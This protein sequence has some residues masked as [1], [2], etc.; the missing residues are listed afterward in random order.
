MTAKFHFIWKLVQKR[1]L[2]SPQQYF[3]SVRQMINGVNMN[4][5]PINFKCNQFS[6]HA[7]FSLQRE[8]KHLK[9]LSGV[10]LHLWNTLFLIWLPKLNQMAVKG[11]SY[12]IENYSH[13]HSILT[14][15]CHRGTIMWQLNHS[16]YLSTAG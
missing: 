10:F 13:T 5:H 12:C 16:V 8:T 7:F 4:L 15:V 1:K 6:L 2:Y 9:G 14:H 3:M 11:R